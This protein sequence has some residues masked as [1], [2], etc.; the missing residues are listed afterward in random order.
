VIPRYDPTYTFGDLRNSL[1]ERSAGNPGDGLRDRLRSIYA[2]KHAFLF[3]HAR[4]ALFAV[5]RAYGRP[6]DVLMPAYNCIVVPEAVQCAGYHPRFVDV[7]LESLNVTTEALARSRTPRTTVV[8]ATHLFGIPCDIEGAVNFGREHGLLVVEDAAAAMGAEYGGRYVGR[9]GHAAIISFQSTK[10]I[11]GEDGGALLTDDDELAERVGRLAKAAMAP[12]PCISFFARA[13]GRKIALRRWAYLPVLQGYRLLGKERMHEVVK[14]KF[15][16]PGRYIKGCSP[17]Q[18]ALAL[19]Q[20]GRLQENLDRRRRLAEIYAAGLAGQAGIALPTVVAPAKP[21]WIQ[22]PVRVEDKR[23]FYR[24]MQKRGVDLSWTYRYSCAESF[25]QVGF[26]E[27]DLAA[28]TVL[29]LPTYPSLTDDEARR[30][31]DAAG[32]CVRSNRR[33]G[34]AA[35]KA[36]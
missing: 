23:G 18:S 1:R 21:S 34:H 2:V 29:G 32:R 16:A 27:A 13:V 6:G 22:Y 17:F 28:R 33:S 8:L 4:T 7:D 9:F 20:M 15:P 10:V 19:V 25:G 35:R 5:L 12:S 30:I 24:R 31:C 26:P 3:D 14:P 36:P 11:S